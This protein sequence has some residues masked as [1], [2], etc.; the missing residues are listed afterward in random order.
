MESGNFIGIGPLAAPT[1]SCSEWLR[2][3]ILPRSTP[4]N[5]GPN[6]SYKRIPVPRRVHHVAQLVGIEPPLELFAGRV[7]VALGNAYVPAHSRRG[8]AVPVIYDMSL[9]KHPEMHP[10]QRVAYV[11]GQLNRVVRRAAMI[12]TISSASGRRSPNTTACRSNG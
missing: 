1:G 3:S 9:V 5:I 11:G 6:V 2:V 8:A 10:K 12:V 4:S 7:D